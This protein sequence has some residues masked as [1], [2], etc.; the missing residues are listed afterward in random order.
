MGGMKP[1]RPFRIV[2]G[3]KL[4]PAERFHGET[5][6]PDFLHV[7][8]P[9]AIELHDVDVVR[10]HFFATAEGSLHPRDDVPVTAIKK[11]RLNPAGRGQTRPLR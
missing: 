11:P 2:L 7:L 5:R 9:V 4:Y 1:C 6:V 8:N 10:R 3:R